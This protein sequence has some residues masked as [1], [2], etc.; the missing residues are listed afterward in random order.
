M[1]DAIETQGFMLEIAQNPNVSPLVFIEVKE[2]TNFNGFGGSASEI[3][4]THLR[5]Q[6]KEFLM[7]LQDFGNFDVDTNYLSSDPGQ[8]AMRAA[9][10]ARTLQK[11]RTTYSDGSGEE[12]DGYVLS[13]PKSGGV[14]AKVDGSFSIRIT[15]VPVF[16]EAP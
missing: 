7:G 12:F 14:D 16:N 11:F 9:K 5:S 2:I 10:G 4:R 3:D 15:G 6:A 8:K 13:G 1:S